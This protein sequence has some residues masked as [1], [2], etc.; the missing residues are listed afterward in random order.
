MHRTLEQP[1]RARLITPHHRDLPVRPVLRYDS[2]EP[3]AV[4][5]AF[6]ARVSAGGR[7][8]TWSFARTLLEEGLQT[9]AGIGDVRIRPYGRSHTVLEFRVPQG[10]AVIRFGTAALRRFLFRSYALVGPGTENPGPALERSL[11]ALLGGV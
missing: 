11:A 4:H 7:G 5:I 3:F 2:V 8:V 1:V 10:T 6:P 9:P